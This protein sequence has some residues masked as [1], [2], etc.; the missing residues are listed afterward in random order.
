MVKRPFDK[1]QQYQRVRLSSISGEGFISL[2]EAA[3]E[4]KISAVSEMLDNN[5]EKALWARFAIDVT[6]RKDSSVG[7]GEGGCNKNFS[8]SGRYA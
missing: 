4:G 1:Q 8:E 6:V 7:G 3:R 2:G 5:G